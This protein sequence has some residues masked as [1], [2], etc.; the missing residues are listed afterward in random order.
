MIALHEIDREIRSLREQVAVA[1]E[2][3]NGAWLRLRQQHGAAL[4]TTAAVA[5]GLLAW[6]RW[7][8]QTRCV[9]VPHERGQLDHLQA[10]GDRDAKSPASTWL[11]M[12]AGVLPTVVPLFASRLLPSPWREWASHPLARGLIASGLGRIANLAK[13]GAR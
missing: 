5:T 6:W 12:L 10:G 1:D 13:K 2:A 9:P 4:F 3:G 8:R 7:R 11:G